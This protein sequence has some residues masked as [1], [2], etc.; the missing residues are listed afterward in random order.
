[1]TYAVL[2]STT[3]SDVVNGL[4]KYT[5]HNMTLTADNVEAAQMIANIYHRRDRHITIIDSETGGVIDYTAIKDLEQM[6]WSRQY[7]ERMTDDEARRH[8]A[9]WGRGYYSI[10]NNFDFQQRLKRLPENQKSDCQT[11]YTPRP[12]TAARTDFIFT[13]FVCG[14]GTAFLVWALAEALK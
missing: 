5:S 12:H 6:E 3:R 8:N 7:Y 14:L 4:R 9:T 11:V 2:I 1:M 13:W 10:M